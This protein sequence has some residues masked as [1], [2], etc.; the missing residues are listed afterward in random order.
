[1]SLYMLCVA[2]SGKRHAAMEE[3]AKQYRFHGI[4]FCPILVGR[5]G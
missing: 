3:L 1:M 5:E 2:E 4:W